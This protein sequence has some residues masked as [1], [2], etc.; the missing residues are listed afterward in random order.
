VAFVVT[1]DEG[2]L[3]TRI[4]IDGKEATTG[5][6]GGNVFTNAFSAASA[7]ASASGGG[8]A[9]SQTPQTGDPLPS[10]LAALACAAMLL[11][12]GVAG[13]WR[14]RADR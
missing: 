7:T 6:V 9:V 5:V 11:G 13:L 3:A 1:D 8:T 2:A 4:L 12:I 10:G 14:R